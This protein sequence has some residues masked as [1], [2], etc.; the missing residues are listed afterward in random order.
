[1]GFVAETE[2][3]KIARDVRILPVY[4][5]TS[6]IHNWIINRSQ[7]T[8]KNYPKFRKPITG[9]DTAYESMMYLRYPDLRENLKD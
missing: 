9:E 2:I 6:E 7:M 8:I 1:M 4:D 5:G 3:N